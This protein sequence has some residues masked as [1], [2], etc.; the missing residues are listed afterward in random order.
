M[1]PLA[2]MVDVSQ[3]VDSAEHVTRGGA[4]GVG[5]FDDIAER[6]AKT[7]VAKIEK[8]ES[9]G[10]VIDG[11]F[12]LDAEAVHDDFGAAPLQ[13]GFLDLLVGSVAADLAAEAVILEVNL[14]D[15]ARGGGAVGDGGALR[16]G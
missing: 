16:A 3:S 13:E 11:G 9:E 8:P 15:F 4:Y 6:I 2:L 12:G 1:D 10:M 7:L 5:I 14:L